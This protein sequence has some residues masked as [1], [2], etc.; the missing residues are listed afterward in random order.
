MF[1]VPKFGGE[2]GKSLSLNFYTFFI[3]KL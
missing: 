1:V 2:F 3:H